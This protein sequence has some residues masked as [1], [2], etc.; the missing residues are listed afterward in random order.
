MPVAIAASLTVL[1][2]GAF[3]YEA[4]SRSARVLAA[5]LTADH[6]KCFAANRVF[7]IHH[8]PPATAAAYLS[9]SFGWQPHLPVQPDLN[10]EATRPCLYGE[11]RLAHLMYRHD[12]QPVSLFMLPGTTRDAGLIEVLGHEAAI[13]S[14]NNRTFVLVARAPRA[15]VERL[16]ASLGAAIQ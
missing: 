6:V 14:K 10:L 3:L 11:G 8:E 4:T 13:W 15:E 12:G 5:E 9:A 16:A 7:G 1:V 2:G